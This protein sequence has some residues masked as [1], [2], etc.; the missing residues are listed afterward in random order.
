MPSPIGHAMAG[1][2]AAWTADLIPGTRARR[3]A[4]ASASPFRRAGGGVTLICAGLGAAPDLDLLLGEHRMVTH[5]LGAVVLVWLAAG[6][7]AAIAHRPVVR[8]S[9]TCAGAYATH[10]LLDWLGVD[11]FPPPGIEALWPLN[12]TWYISGLNVFRE[13]ARQKFLTVPSLIENLTAIVQEVAILGP[14]LVVLWLVRV[15][16]LAGLASEVTRGDHPSQ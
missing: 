1:I 8:V 12:H 11:R 6:S 5:S 16:A 9:L 7:I 4:P 15:K 3:V 14:A 2:A 13:V 10:L